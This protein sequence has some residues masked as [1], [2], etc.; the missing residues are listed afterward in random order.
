MTTTVTA[1]TTSA[2]VDSRRFVLLCGL[3]PAILTV[4]LVVYRPGFISEIDYAAYDVLL[5]SIPVRAPDARVAIVDVDDLSLSEIGQWPWRR[6]RVAE[7]ISRLR[8]QGAAVVALDVM[9]AEPD[10]SESNQPSPWDETLA[11]ALPGG[12]IVLGYAL[13][14]SRTDVG[15]RD[16]VLH[17]LAVPIVQP[18]GGASDDAPLFHA[19]GAVCSLP[20]LARAAGRSG[21]LN[22]I[23][24]ADGILRRVPLVVEYAGTALPGLA[25]SAV[26]VATGAQPLALRSRN[27]NT[28]SLELTSGTVPLDGRSNLLVRYRGKKRSFPYV[29][30]VDV[31]AGRTA[32]DVFRNAIVFVGTTALGTREEVS[33]PFDTRFA[34]VEVQATVADNLV[35]GDYLSRAEHAVTIE[36]VTVLAAGIAITLLVARVGLPLGTAAGAAFLIV[37]WLAMRWQLTAKGEYLSPVFPIIGLMASLGAATVARIAQERSRADRATRET[38]LAHQLMVRSL[39]SLTEVRDADTGSH[40]RRIQQYSRLLAEEL[41][42]H[43]SFRNYLTPERIDL[44]SS[45]APLHDIG[46]VGVPDHLLNK[47]GELTPDEYQEMKKHPVYGLDVINNAQRDVG[48][49]DDQIL[50]MAKDIVYTH[51]EWWDGRGYPRGLK[52]TAIPIAGRLVAVVDVYDAM[53]ARRRYR[54]PM[55]HQEA[56]DLIV[57][58]KATHFDPDVVDAFVRVAARLSEVTRAIANR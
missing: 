10:R 43:R 56:V 5:R 20:V 16:C 54:Q 22:A 13:T 3:A 31:L 24:D 30:A 50:T 57:A 18:A 19:E 1:E 48:A 49:G 21:F 25:L 40:S 32:A 45:L 51:H 6:D 29:S 42:N 37:I 46:K 17:P 36:V 33:T 15:Q 53:T 58:G 55:S 2:R 38:D 12:R 35:R 23:P 26:L 52:G 11:S 39:L 47:P 7:L 27:A 8:E 4:A 34:G 28:T 44:L 41:A 14:F 9:F